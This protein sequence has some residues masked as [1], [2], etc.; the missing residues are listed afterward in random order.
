MYFSKIIVNLCWCGLY[1]DALYSPGNTVIQLLNKQIHI[2][3][4]TSAHTEKFSVCFSA[5]L[6]HSNMAISSQSDPYT[7]RHHVHI[8]ITHLKLFFHS[9]V[10][11]SRPLN[12]K[13]P[14]V[15]RYR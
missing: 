5:C 10:S 4:F 11:I 3:T 1:Y 12:A 7:P 8:G 9:Q 6:S 15:T 2:G 14:T 13:S